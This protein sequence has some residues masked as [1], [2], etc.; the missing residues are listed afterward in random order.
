VATLANPVVVLME[1]GVL[2]VQLVPEKKVSIADATVSPQI[3]GIRI[4]FTAIQ[5]F[6]PDMFFHM[7]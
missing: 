7:G 5:Y 1:L 3:E 2:R 4:F 6:L